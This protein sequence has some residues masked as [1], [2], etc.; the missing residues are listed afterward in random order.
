M[1]GA[2]FIATGAA[3]V[4]RRYLRMRLPMLDMGETLRG[5]VYHTN[6]IVSSVNC[7]LL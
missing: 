6:N 7:D 4:A 1:M 2:L 3:L 5:S